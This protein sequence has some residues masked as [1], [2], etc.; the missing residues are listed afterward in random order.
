MFVWNYNSPLTKTFGFKEV[1]IQYSEDGE[2]WIDIPDANMFE[3]AS[4]GA[5]YVYNTTVEFND[6]VAQSVRITALSNYGGKS[7]GL[8]EIRFTY[9]PVRA[10]KPSPADETADVAFGT[11]FKWRKGREAVTHKVYLGTD[12]VAV[13]NGTASVHTVN[14]NSYLPDLTMASTYYWRVDEINN[15]MTPSVWK[16]DVWSISTP[17]SILIEG[18]EKGYGNTGADAVYKT[19]KDGVE[20][21]ISGTNG[22]Y[23]GRSSPPYLQTINHSGGHSSPMQYRNGTRLYSEVVADTSKL[24]NGTDWSIGHPEA[25]VI[26]FRADANEVNEPV[27]DRLYVKLSGG[28]KI[29]Y[30]GPESYIR[31]AAWTKWEVPLSGVTLGN[32]TS[33][34]IG[35]ERLGSTGGTGII[36]FDDIQLVIP[37]EA[38]D[39]GTDDLLARYEMENNVLDSSGNGL[40]G[41]LKGTVN[42]GPTYAAGLTGYGMALVVDGN[43]DCVDLGEREEFNPAGSFSISIWARISDWSTNWGHVMIANR[44]EGTVG[45]QIRRYSSNSLSFTTRGISNDDMNSNATPPLREWFNVTCVYDSEARTK[46]IYIDGA[47]DKTVN[48]TGDVTQIP[49]TTHNTYIGARANSDNTG[50][51]G[52][53]KGMLD[54][55]MLYDRALSAG[56]AKFLA[57][58]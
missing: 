51:E 30:D 3:R 49:A 26:W 14:T 7:T 48:M 1:L 16:G 9:I 31:R 28:N 53:F 4:G 40:N 6:V 47:L 12:K 33:I 37:V 25:L 11:M 29:L 34:T 22:S 21:G 15:D 52:F 20:L 43:D 46:S 42:G 56:E 27:T 54:Q 50:R 36:Y 38:S 55:I 10:R 57:T 39:P 32:V 5:K 17:S 18:F 35:A 44:G 23:M 8:S 24:L 19:W 58:P 41:T 2:T 13:T 45:W